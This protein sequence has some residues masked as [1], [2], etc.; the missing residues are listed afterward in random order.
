MN[1]ANMYFNGLGVDQDRTRAALYF[2][3]A[4]RLGNANADQA[5]Q[6]VKESLG[7]DDLKRIENLVVEWEARPGNSSNR[8]DGAPP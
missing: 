8:R 4:V 3:L 6:L 7:V 5:L 2:T 1:M